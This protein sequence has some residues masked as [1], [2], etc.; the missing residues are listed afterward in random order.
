MG[1]ST[2]KFT[3]VF[4]KNFGESLDKEAL[5]RLFEPFGK[6]TSCTVM[7]DAEGKSKGFGFVAYEQPEQA[8]KA[9]QEMNDYQIEGTDHKL[10]VCRAQKKSERDAEL[11]RKHDLQKGVNL[12]VKNLDD[13]VNDEAL[14]KYFES[15]GKITS[16]K[17]MTDESGRSKGFG[18]VCFE[19]PDEATNA[20][21]EMNSKMVCSK[22]LYVAMAQRKEDRREQCVAES[23][24]RSQRMGAMSD[25]AKN[26]TNEQKQL[27]GERIC[28]L[29]GRLYPGHKNAE[30]ITGMMLEIDKSELIMML[31]DLDHFKSKVEEALSV[32]Q[33]TEQK[34]LLWERIYALIAR[35]YPDHKDTEKVTGMILEIDTL[36]FTMMLQDLDHFKSKVEEASSALRSAAKIN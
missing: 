22:P 29:V 27:L 16:C 34:Q 15:H 2:N 32:L 21:T 18:F 13:T 33:S 17:V 14:R 1:E 10:V 36:E 5:Q 11:K 28:A 3:N 4:I 31:Q 6:I 7:T 20:L 30:K 26:I 23:Q 12:Y 24:P 19:K 25:C 8:E 9:V 35:L